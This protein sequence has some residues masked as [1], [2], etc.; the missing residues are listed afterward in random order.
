MQRLLLVGS[1]III[2][3]QIKSRWDFARVVV[4]GAI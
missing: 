4:T 1:D 3:G 2:A